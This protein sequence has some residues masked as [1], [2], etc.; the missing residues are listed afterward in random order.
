M[1]QNA[2]KLT[3]PY[4]SYSTGDKHTR[5]YERVCQPHIPLH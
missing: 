3:S 1:Y 5:W 4:P 2:S